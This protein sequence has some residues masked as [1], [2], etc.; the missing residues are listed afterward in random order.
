MRRWHRAVGLVALGFG[1]L[2]ALQLAAAPAAAAPPWRTADISGGD[3]RSLAFVPADPQVVV[4]GTASG[5]VYLSRDGGGTW[6]HAGR[7]YALPG[8]VVASLH[9]DVNRPQRLWAGL[10]GMWGGGAVVASDDLGA[11]WEVRAVRPDD[12][13]FT[14]SSVPGE[15]GRLVIGTDSGVWGSADDGATWRHLSAGHAGIVEVS[16]L[17]VDPQRP[18]ILIAGTFRRAYR[19]DDGGA[20]WRGVFDGMVLDSQIFS[21]QPVP[22]KPGSV[23]ASTCGWV[24]RTLDRGES[25]TRFK[26]GLAER[27]TTSFQVLPNGRLLAGT[28]AGMYVSD[29]GGARWQRR[30]R[31]DLAILAIAHHRARPDVV[32]AGTEGSG[33]WRSEDGGTTYRPASRG[34]TSARV[35]ALSVGGDELLVAVA[36]GGPVSGIYASRDGVRLLHQFADIPTVLALAAGGGEPLAATERG[37]F[38]RRQGIWQRVPA[39]GETRVDQVRVEGGRV[40]V[41]TADGVLEERQQRFEPAVSQA[42]R[43]ASREGSHGE[44]TARWEGQGAG[45]SRLLQTGSEGYPRLVVGEGEARLYRESDG[46]WHSLRLPFPARDV[47]AA[48]VFRDR[49]Y[50]GTSGYGLVSAALDEL[51]EPAGGGSPVSAGAPRSP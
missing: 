41:R 33:V 10:R 36:H 29:D 22:G 38:R 34:L 13:L 6:R 7:V 42:W 51:L 25:W 35:S 31:A 19:S 26:D 9:F 3:V 44:L 18:Q 32:L 27:R 45:R 39:L 24:Y 23:W 20:T 37:L 43:A 46:R 30:S 47:L 50:L 15:E 5:Q 17:L 8:W 2:A 21:L 4:A 11:S 49:L 16:S 48:A 28:V 40:L 12:G 14:L 1:A